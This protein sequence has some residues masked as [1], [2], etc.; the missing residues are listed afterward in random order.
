M[1][2]LTLIAASL[3]A[4]LN[5]YAQ[6]DV[7]FDNFGGGV[8]RNNR[9]GADVTVG[10]GVVVQLYASMTANGTFAP[11]PNSVFQ[12]GVIG[13]GFF[14]GGVVR[15][16]SSIIGAGGAAFMEV[17]AWESAYGATYEEA[18]AAAAMGGRP[19]LRGIS[20]RFTVGATGNPN[21]S[22]PGTPVP[23]SDL[24]P[25]FSVN[26]PEPSVIA[27]G[28]IGAGALLVLRRRK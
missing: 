25:G 19:A 5:I 15:I 7:I 12:V 6:G 13:D 23:L 3:I 22:P 21:A 27:L 8:V 9:T 17:R 16:P 26:V 24:V 1:K 4:A 18:I 11:V 20:N 28:L 2:K 14:D 10:D